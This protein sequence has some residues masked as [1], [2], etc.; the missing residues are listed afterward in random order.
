MLETAAK[1]ATGS[2]RAICY[3]SQAYVQPGT[4]A[5]SILGVINPAPHSLPSPPT[6]SLH[7]RE[8]DSRKFSGVNCLS[9]DSRNSFIRQG[10]K[11]AIDAESPSSLAWFG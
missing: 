11:M 3:E 7:S 6:Q 4:T 9:Q 1:R 2:L 10:S 8:T 5:Q